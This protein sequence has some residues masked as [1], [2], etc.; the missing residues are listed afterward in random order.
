MQTGDV[1]VH[2]VFD[3]VI[4]LPPD[5]LYPE[6]PVSAWQGVPGGL[7]REGMLPVPFGRFL[8]DDRQGHRVLFDL[9]GGVS[10]ELVPGGAPPAVREL[11]PARLEELGCPLG[12]VDQ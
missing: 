8:A 3:G 2:S 10:P 12:S 11:L 4:P 1:A 9:G 6:V 5:L 7:D